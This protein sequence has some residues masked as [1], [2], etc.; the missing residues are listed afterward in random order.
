MNN[1]AIFSLN[2]MAAPNID[3]RMMAEFRRLSRFSGSYELLANE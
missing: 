2:S 1:R 3:E